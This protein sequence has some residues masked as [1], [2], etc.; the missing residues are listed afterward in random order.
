V[1]WF[2]VLMD[3]PSAVHL[4]KD[5]S[6]ANSEPEKEAQLHARCRGRQG[7]ERVADG[8]T[9]EKSREWIAW[10]VLEDQSRSTLRTRL[11]I[12]AMSSLSLRPTLPQLLELVDIK[13]SASQPG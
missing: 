10:L 4:A 7:V 5:A 1:R 2:D 13:A 3:E 12:L 11:W 8:E 6:K 9:G